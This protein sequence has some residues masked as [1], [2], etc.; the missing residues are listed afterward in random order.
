MIK[1]IT[2]LFLMVAVMLSFPLTSSAFVRNSLGQ[3]SSALRH[4]MG[5]GS[6]VPFQIAN[7]MVVGVKYSIKVGEK[8]T[9][10]EVSCPSFSNNIGS[11][12]MRIY[13]WTDDYKTTISKKPVV[14]KRFEDY[15]DNSILTISLPDEVELTGDI[16]LTFSDTTE[17]VGIWKYPVGI[18]ET[19]M[20]INGQ[21]SDGAP[22]GTFCCVPLNLTGTADQPTKNPYESIEMKNYDIQAN[23]SPSSMTVSDA[24]GTKYNSLNITSG[25][26]AGYYNM[27]FGNESPKGIEMVVINNGVMGDS[28]QIQVVLDDLLKGDVIAELNVEYDSTD[29]YWETLSGKITQNITGVHNVFV[30]FTYTGY[31]PVTMKFVKDEPGDSKQEIRLKEF[32]DTKNFELKDTY[33]D[34]WVATDM[35][36]RKLPDYETVGKYNP[37]K[38]V[39]MFY[40]T[41]H[42]Q[43]PMLNLTSMSNN[44]EV[45][46]TY[47][48]DVSEIYNNFDYPKWGTSG[49]WNESIY[50]YYHGLDTWVMRKQLEM[51]SAAGVDSLFFDATNGSQTWTGGYMTLGKVMHQMHNEGIK[52]P[53]MVFMMP[54]AEGSDTVLSLE[55]IY[56]NM[57]STGLYSDCWYYW[58]GK[59]LVMAYYDMLKNDTGYKDLNEEHQEILNFFTFRPGQPLY[60]A[61]PKSDDQ[62]PWLEI[63]PQFPY[64]KSDKY[65]CECVSVGVAQNYHDGG[66][67]AMNNGA[68]VY[69]RSYTYKDR[70]SNLSATSKYYGYNFAEQ[71]ER[72]YQ[73]NPEFVFID[74]WNEWA[75]SHSTVW[76]GT[77]GGYSDTFSDEYSRDIEPTKGDLKD[78]YY[79][80]LVSS[81]RKFKG[82]RQTP[83]ASKEKT[84]DLNGDFSQW[85]DVGPEFVGYKGGTEPRNARGVS[86]V[87]KKVVY[88]NDTGRNDIVL[89]KVARDSDNLYFYVETAANL[90]PYT[91]PSWMRLFINTDRGYSTGWEGY[92]YVINRVSPTA[93]KA[94]LERSKTGWNWEKVADVDYKVDGNKMMITVPRN[95]IGVNGNVDIEFKWNDNMQAQGD[96]MDFYTNGDTAPIGRFAYHYVENISKMAKIKDEPVQPKRSASDKLKYYTVMFLDKS[97]AF[98]KNT[99]TKIDPD[100]DAVTP[101]I[102]DDKTLV[103]LRFLTESLG[104]TVTWKDETQTARIIFSNKRIFVTV[105]SSTLKVEKEKYQLETPAVEMDGRIYVPLRDIVEAAGIDCV[106]IDPGIII[107]GDNANQIVGDQ[108]VETYLQT[109]DE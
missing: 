10:A 37:D 81:I 23:L 14:E 63:Y 34:T 82:V 49:Y 6:H 85:D 93:E 71:W 58:K 65:G 92:D 47:P 2:A 9:S 60:T 78:C 19:A 8:L 107:V 94:V 97:K 79:Y 39:G 102:I 67:T 80:Q 87:N 104:A 96:I 29:N 11:M 90:T 108:D 61:G 69:G 59:P 73:L 66:K 55:R 50:G 28:G 27:D 16:L 99:A 72:A 1:K 86:V 7:D 31:S 13:N 68:D 15:N 76:G 42:A 74:G 70:F 64:G 103:P 36:G 43:Q 48:G 26:Y 91:D 44:Q 56:E 24:N 33:A 57:Y 25:A 53:G 17:N 32:N 75:S 83:E 41:W 62:W 77:K 84:I 3:G 101:K 12:T 40:W 35:L 54:F 98:V 38:Q 20:Y 21:I 89:S 88:T 5:T 18:P 30:T 52:T 51:L 109:Q 100:N 46:D 45:L 22:E 106:W 95:L 105:G 4:K